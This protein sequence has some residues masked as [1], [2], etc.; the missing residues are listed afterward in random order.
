M[1]FQKLQNFKNHIVLPLKTEKLL[2]KEKNFTQDNPQ[3]AHFWG[4]KALFQGIDS[5]FLRKS[6]FDIKVLMQLENLKIT[7]KE[8]IFNQNY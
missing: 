6:T 1:N 4:D 7:Q 3:I 5:S 8:C 2:C